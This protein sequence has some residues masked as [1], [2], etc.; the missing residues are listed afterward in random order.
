MNATGAGNLARAAARDRHA[1]AARLDRLRV[2]RRRPARRG[3]ARAPVRGVRSDRAALGVRRDE[4]RGRA[5]GAGGLAAHTVVRTAWL[6]GVDGRNFVDTMLRLA[7]ER[8]AVQVVTDQVGSPTWSGHLAPALLGLLEREV[9]G[10][11][12]LTGAGEVSWNGFAAGDLPPGRGR[13][14]RR[15][16]DQRADGAPGAAPGLLGARVRARRRAA[17]AALAGRAGRLSGGAGR[18]LDERVGALHACA[19]WDDA[20]PH[21]TARVRRRRLHRLD[22]R[23]PARARARRRGDRARQ[24][25]LRGARGEP[26]RRR[27]RRPASASCAARSRIREAVAARDRGRRGPRRS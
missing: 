18:I 4:A 16:G 14:P 22:V 27:S 1:A 7:G 19:P 8:E 6:F 26:P 9:S 10:L 21:E 25:H 2:R 13:L 12:H 11:V 5:R 3:R 23:A 20:V 15:A 24:A 17:D